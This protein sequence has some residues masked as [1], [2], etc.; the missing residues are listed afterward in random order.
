MA[1]A[2]K[3]S[4]VSTAKKINVHY[5]TRVEGHGNIIAEVDE[6]GKVTACHWEVPEAPRF[7]EAMMLGRSYADVH[8]IASRICGICSIGHQLASLQ[9]TEEALGVMVSEQT[10]FLRKLAL[11]GENIQSH[12]LHVGYLV[13]PDLLGV[14]SVIPLASSHRQELLHLVKSRAMSNEFCRL[15]S[16]RTTHP[17]RLMVGGMAKLP[18][19][20]D[21]ERLR[22]ILVAAVP[23]MRAVVDLFAAVK[24][25]FP[26]FTRETEYVGLT[27]PSEYGLYW[28]EVA[29]S[30]APKR[31]AALYQ[32]VAKEY[33]VP[34]STAK[35]SRG[36]DGPYMVGAL[37]RFNLNHSQLGPAG[38]EAAEKLGLKAPCHN[39]YY[40]SLAQIVEVVHSIEDSISLTDRLLS[41]G[42]RPETPASVRT[43]PGRGVSAV[44]VPR[45]LLF[46]AYEYDENGRMVHAD[47]VIPTNQNHANIQKDLEALTPLIARQDKD[48]VELKLSMLVRA[49]DPCIS[50]SAH[51][52]DLSPEERGLVKFVPAGSHHKTGEK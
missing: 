12:L 8:H 9:A 25:N 50:C 47:C 39:P 24:G 15:V 41:R 16:G 35:W 29:S 44:E 11:H 48:S 14:D 4:T 46:H 38:R 18:S 34:A 32:D 45:G 33:C 49:Y 17:Q 37:A 43:V 23:E 3:E 13:L 26:D 52:L 30:M 28:G 2:A 21:L 5:L 31:P 6:A 40:I 10:L 36:V 1:K 22:E 51:R 19:V 42:L 20:E 27:S 7:F